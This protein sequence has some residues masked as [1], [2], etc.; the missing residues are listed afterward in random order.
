MVSNG[1]RVG[2]VIYTSILA[3]F[4]GGYYCFKKADIPFPGDVPVMAEH[5][6]IV[7]KIDSLESRLKG[8]SLARTDSFDEYIGLREQLLIA[9]SDSVSV[10]GSSEFRGY[11]DSLRYSRKWLGLG[12]F[13]S[14]GAPLLGFFSALR[15]SKPKK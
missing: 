3:G 8:F 5:T 10:V 13:L 2:V 14:F 1:L 15:L 11:S 6:R 7:E 4:G 12:Y 9:R